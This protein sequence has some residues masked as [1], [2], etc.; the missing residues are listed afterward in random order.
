MSHGVFGGEYLKSRGGWIEV[1]YWAGGMEGYLICDVAGGGAAT[2]LGQC[3]CRGRRPL[4]GWG[5]SV[6]RLMVDRKSI[7]G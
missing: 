4:Q 1:M 3:D 5:L 7:S 6:V 2:G